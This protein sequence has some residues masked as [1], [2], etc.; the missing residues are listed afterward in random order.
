MVGPGGVVTVAQRVAKDF[1]KGDA[2]DLRG[3]D[4]PTAEDLVVIAR[5]FRDPRYEIIRIVYF[6]GD[7][8]A[9]Q[10]REEEVVGSRGIF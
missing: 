3:Q 2:I 6:K 9:S 4:A 10:T 5:V 1:R 8:I 7:T